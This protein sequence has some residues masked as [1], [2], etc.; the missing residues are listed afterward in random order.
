MFAY[1]VDPER[2]DRIVENAVRLRLPQLRVIDDV[3][4]ID[5]PVDRVLVDVPCSNTAVLSRRVEARHRLREGDPRRMATLQ[6]R[7]LESAFELLRSGGDVDD[8][9]RVVYS[10]CSLEAAEN[11][12]VVGS[13][14]AVL[15][16]EIRDRETVFPDPPGCDGGFWA[17]L[18]PARRA[19][20]G[21]R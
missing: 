16:A 2:R 14:A 18:G 8:G 19:S 1:D 10:T 13:V 17:V 5:R 15:G 21:G 4:A 7:L 20:P 9:A 11:E 3:R 6:R 12:D